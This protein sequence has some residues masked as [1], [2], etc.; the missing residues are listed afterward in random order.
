[1][2]ATQT[3]SKPLAEEPPL[4][5]E[6]AWR[7]LAL[8]SG[9]FGAAIA[10]G[11]TGYGYHRDELYFIAIG[12]HPAWGYVDQPPLVPLLA[13]AMDLSGHSLVWLRV[14]AAIAGALVVLIAGLIAREFG[15]GRGAQLLAAAAMAVSSVLVA[16]SHTTSTAV[17]DLLTWTVLSWL[18]V[19]ALRDDGRVWLLVGLVAGIGLEI[20]TLPAFLIV[21]LL[22]GVL[23]CGPRRVLGSRWLWG[24]AVIALALW[25]PNVIWQATHHWP[26]L[27][28][29]SAIAA[30]SS[31]SGQ[32]RW[33]FVPYQF[34]LVS[35]VLVPVG[36]AGLWRLARDPALGRWRC[37]AVAYPLLVVVFVATGGKP[38]YLCGLYP[39]LLAAGAAPTLAWMRRGALRVRAALLAAALV[40]SAAV[41]V[42]LMLPIVPVTALPATPIVAIN[43][44]AGETVGWPQLTTTVRQVFDALPEQQREHAIVLGVNYG[45]A[46]ALL[47]FAPEIPAYSGHNSLSDLG[48][49]PSTTQTA[50]VLG[51]PPARL[52]LWFAE[53]SPVATIDNGVHLDNQEQ[54]RTVW[55]CTGPTRD[56]PGLWQDMR[57]LG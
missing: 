23:L 43:Y 32:P 27:E 35:P 4:P 52:R 37:F 8:I 41:S 50:I 33:L 44:D 38:Y 26:Q 7:G 30:G 28:M 45:E 14:P 55:L 47:H 2:S 31:G 21:A 13:H 48:P 18:V 17:F 1:M 51:Y 34:V 40:L 16:V 10:A 49:P 20:K 36:F 9:L 39:A 11:S 12:G 19:W 29:S 25:A 22:L 42:V 56:W 46:G 6:V 3:N 24:G 57:R 54:D 15:G 53:V 5:T